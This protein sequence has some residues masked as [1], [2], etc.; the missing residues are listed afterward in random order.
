MGFLTGIIGFF[1][2][3]LFYI[4]LFV[5]ILL[6][7]V[8]LA[9]RHHGILTILAL[10]LALVGLHPQPARALD[11]GFME[12]CP[13]LD[14]TARE[15]CQLKAKIREM[16]EAKEEQSK[17]NTGGVNVKVEQKQESSSKSGAGAGGGAWGEGLTAGA[18]PDSVLDRNDLEVGALYRWYV[19]PSQGF[20]KQM[21]DLPLN[22]IQAWWMPVRNVGFGLQW[23]RFTLEGGKDYPPV[24]GQGVD[25]SGDLYDKA[26][27]KF[28][29]DRI[30]YDIVLAT[31]RI[32]GSLNV[33]N[34][35]RGYMQLGS[36][37]VNAKLD[38]WEVDGNGTVRAKTVEQQDSRPWYFSGIIGYNLGQAELF[39]NIEFLVAGSDADQAHKDYNFGFSAV[40][41]GA[42]AKF[43]VWK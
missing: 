36:G 3:P 7:G 39:T 15:N 28:G 27:V 9:L 24:M 11:L 23:S 8:F 30:E 40:T 5:L 37:F 10:A 25:A 35:W 31:L 33:E 1:V 38:V 21:L 26:I 13:Q 12:L 34:K 42:V 2:K 20:D 22:G 32:G 6:G 19:I 14:K 17:Q 41:F 4:A 18:V 43:N 16:K 29:V